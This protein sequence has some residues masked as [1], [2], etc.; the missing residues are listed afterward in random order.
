MCKK[1]AA[2]RNYRRCKDDV[3]ATRLNKKKLER[4]TTAKT[5]SLSAASR[6]DVAAYRAALRMSSSAAV[7]LE[8]SGLMGD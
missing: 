2:S 1:S 8:M 6:A 3:F 5:V 4:P 7:G